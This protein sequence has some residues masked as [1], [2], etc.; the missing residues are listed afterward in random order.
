MLESFIEFMRGFF[1]LFG[2]TVFFLF[3][4]VSI[5]P[6]LGRFA[7]ILCAALAGVI[8]VFVAFKLED[9]RKERES[10]DGR[11]NKPD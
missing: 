3:I 7:V 5:N 9:R 4:A 2:L 6:D 11:T 1:S 8:D 10:N